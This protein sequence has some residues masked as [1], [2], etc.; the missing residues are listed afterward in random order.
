MGFDELVFIHAYWCV[1]P[2]EEC[3]CPESPT[4]EEGE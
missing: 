4:P 3:T 2:E 1:W